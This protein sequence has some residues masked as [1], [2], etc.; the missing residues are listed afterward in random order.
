MK[1]IVRRSFAPIGVG[2]GR[3]LRRENEIEQVR[4][5][6]SPDLLGLRVHDLALLDKG[7]SPQ[8][9]AASCLHRH[10]DCH[11]GCVRGAM[12]ATDSDNAAPVVQFG[13]AAGLRLVGGLGHQWVVRRRDRPRPEKVF[14]H[15][16][17]FD[18]HGLCLVQHGHCWRRGLDVGARDRPADVVFA[19]SRLMIAGQ[20]FAV[21]L[22]AF[23]CYR[24]TSRFPQQSRS[25]RLVFPLQSGNKL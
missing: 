16:Q 12:V 5:P 2:V 3:S 6:F 19:Q 9:D 25:C 18:G 15:V 24:S 22:A 11:V 10:P 23:P 21:N 13:S 8:L 17:Y 14:V 7:Q 4:R 20:G 1:A